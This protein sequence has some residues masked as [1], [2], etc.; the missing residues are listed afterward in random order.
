M[1]W[2]GHPVDGLMPGMATP[3]QVSQLET[4]PVDQAEVLF[5]QLMIRHHQ[6]GLS[7]ARDGAE[8]GRTPEVRRLAQN[9]VDVQQ[10]EIATMTTMLAERGA[11]P[12][13]FP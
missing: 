3:E 5:L 9:F 8:Y 10:V 6:G 7:M 12:L 4:L 1:A 13:P 11:E 2:M